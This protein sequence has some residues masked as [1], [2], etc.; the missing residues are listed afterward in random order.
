MCRCVWLHLPIISDRI[1]STITYISIQKIITDIG[2]GA[3]HPFYVNGSRIYI[4]I[5]VEKLSWIGCRFP[6]K[7][8]GDLCPKFIR[9][10]Q[11]FVVEQFILFH[12]R[13]VSIFTDGRWWQIHWFF[14]WHYYGKFRFILNNNGNLEPEIQYSKYYNR[15]IIRQLFELPIKYRW[16]RSFLFSMDNIRSSA[17]IRTKPR[18]IVKTTK[19]TIFL[20]RVLVKNETVD[21]FREGRLVRLIFIRYYNR[22]LVGIW[23]KVEGSNWHHPWYNQG[24][25]QLAQKL[26]LVILWLETY[27]GEGSGGALVN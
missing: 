18:W 27:K 14:W 8:F 25:L 7:L 17:Q 13:D 26:L 16:N 21:C 11:W 1:A 20:V 2:G 10:S 12:T 23:W 6:M 4:K 19:I 9:F 24:L 15:K 22:W 3:L 5:I